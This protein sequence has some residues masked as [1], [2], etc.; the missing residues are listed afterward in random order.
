VQFNWEA[1]V[2]WGGTTSHTGELKVTGQ[3]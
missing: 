2:V 3:F 1:A